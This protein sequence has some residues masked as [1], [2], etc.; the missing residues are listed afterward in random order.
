MQQKKKEKKGIKGL[1]GNQSRTKLYKKLQMF[2]IDLALCNYS[3]GK[4]NNF[5]GKY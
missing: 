2:I 1:K 3:G 5:I 4:P